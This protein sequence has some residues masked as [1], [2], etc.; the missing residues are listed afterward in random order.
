MFPKTTLKFLKDLEEFFTSFAGAGLKV[1]TKNS[2][3]G[4]NYLEYIGYRI[5]RNW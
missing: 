4:Y 5:N 2:R 1:D 3:F